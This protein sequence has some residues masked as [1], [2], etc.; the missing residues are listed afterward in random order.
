MDITTIIPCFK[1][2]EKVARRE[3]GD[4]LVENESVA[5]FF[6]ELVLF[7]CPHADVFSGSIYDELSKEAEA[8]GIVVTLCGR[9]EDKFLEGARVVD[10]SGNELSPDSGLRAMMAPRK[11]I[12]RSGGTF[13]GVEYICEH[14]DGEPT[15][16]FKVKDGDLPEDVQKAIFEGAK[17]KVTLCAALG[18]APKPQKAHVK[19]QVN[20]AV[21]S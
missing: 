6:G 10:E 17:V 9:C 5:A 8:N 7:A 21:G 13:S 3:P 14:T 2:G 4:I 1:M 15:I 12:F 11:T 20:G 16:T 18:P 19:P